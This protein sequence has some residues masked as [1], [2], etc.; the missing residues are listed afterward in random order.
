M[1]RRKSSVVNSPSKKSG[2][3]SVTV[4]RGKS[5][6]PNSP[7]RTVTEVDSGELRDQV[8]EVYS[9]SSNGQRES[10]GPQTLEGNPESAQISRANSLKSNFKSSKPGLRIKSGSK[11]RLR[12]KLATIKPIKI[13][14]Q[15]E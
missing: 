3:D 1:N 15:G 8:D 6:A 9:V 13:E 2:N 12:Q 5:I 14:A 4:K 11:E 7:V 10:S